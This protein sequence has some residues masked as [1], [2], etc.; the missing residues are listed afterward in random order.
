MLGP[1]HQSFYLVN[2]LVR[3]NQRSIYTIAANKTYSTNYT[4]TMEFSGM[5]PNY[6]VYDQFHTE[7]LLLNPPKANSKQLRYFVP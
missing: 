6:A 4:F 7:N 3:P 2:Q 5:L 1:D